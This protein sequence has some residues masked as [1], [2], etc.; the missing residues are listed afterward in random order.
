[1]PC[2]SPVIHFPKAEMPLI[3]RQVGLTVALTFVPL[4]AT[5]IELPAKG[6]TLDYPFR[7]T[8]RYKQR[9]QSSSCPSPRQSAGRDQ[10]AKSS[11]GS[12]CRSLHDR[13]IVRDPDQ[14]R[15]EPILMTGN[16]IRAQQAAL[17]DIG[18]R[19]RE[20]GR[21]SRVGVDSPEIRP[22]D[23]ILAIERKPSRQPPVFACSFVLSVVAIVT[24]FRPE[25]WIVPSP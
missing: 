25:A 2:V 12:A 20:A 15:S 24:S 22:P 6:R 3:A 4:L 11:E 10:A 13:V 21:L 17:D 9:P 19:E 18:A 14:S 23:V 7:M 5:Q 8:L 1:L 16:R